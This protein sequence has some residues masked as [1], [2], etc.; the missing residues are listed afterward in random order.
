MKSD[1][2]FSLQYVDSSSGPQTLVSDT[3]SDFTTGLFKIALGTFKDEADSSNY[4]TDNFTL[5]NVD[6]ANGYVTLS[7]LPVDVSSVSLNVIGG[8]AQIYGVDYTVNGQNLFWNP[9]NLNL[10]DGDKIIAQY[11]EDGTFN[12]LQISWDDFKV[13]SGIMH[14]LETSR[15]IIYVDPIYGSDS[16]EGGPLTPLQN[17]FVATAWAKKGGTVVLY[18]G[19]YNPTEIEMKNLTIMGAYGSRAIISTANVQDTTGS[20][21][22]NSGLTFRDCQGLVS[23]VHIT[24]AREGIYAEDTQN[25]EISNC[26]IHDVTTAVLFDTYSKDC[27]VLRNTIHDASVGLYY[28]YQNWSPQINSNVFYDMSTAVILA[29]ASYFSMSSNTFNGNELCVL[30]DNSSVGVIASNNLTNSNVGINVVGIDSTVEIYNNNFY[31]TTTTV[32]GSG[33][34]TDVS[35]IH[36]DP[37]YTNAYLRNFHLLY[38]STDRSTG[39]GIYDQ[40]MLDRDGAERANDP[41]YDIGAYRYV[42]IQHPAGTDYYVDGSGND[43]INNGS[44]NSPFRTI[45][46][47]MSVADSSVI[48]IS[49]DYDTYYLKLKSENIQIGP[50]SIF[51]YPTDYAYVLFYHEINSADASRKFF[52]LPANIEENDKSNVALNIVHSPAQYYGTDFTMQKDYKSQ[53]CWDGLGLDGIIDVGDVVRVMFKEGPSTGIRELTLHGQYSDLN[54]GRA[55]YVSNSGSDSTVMGG[56]GT[57]SGGNGT[58]EKPYQTIS[59][60]LSQSSAGDYLVVQPGDYTTFTGLDDRVIVPLNDYTSVTDGRVYLEDLFNTART[61]YPNHSLSEVSWNLNTTGNSDASIV[62]GHMCMSFDRTNSVTATSLFDFSPLGTD[63][64]AFEVSA[65]LRQ[66]FDPIF[67]S[68]YNGPNVA[69]FAI[70]DG[71]YTCRIITNGSDSSCWGH[72]DAGDPDSTENFFTE[73][74]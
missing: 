7:S 20:N 33:V 31:G 21:W 32:T 9:V 6:E 15:P 28:S 59:W 25:L 45:D 38:F 39:T 52:F 37:G 71:N 49:G 74:V 14:G 41:S 5:T 19:N 70:N 42:N 48:V 12:D 29:D 57:N 22:E 11:M 62:E 27:K 65:E 58:R 4:V 10:L 54:L 40:Y 60:A 1:S 56:D 67:F 44:A 69:T 43:F 35:S 3:I 23:N 34:I 53:V 63:R 73:Y 55:I 17:L 13:Y 64:T 66:A 68:V 51:V 2:T 16:S 24:E 61:M 50:V 30:L 46:K 26:Q 8:G 36:T 47:A 72:L 18:S